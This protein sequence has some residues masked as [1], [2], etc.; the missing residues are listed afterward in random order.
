MMAAFRR[1]YF[2]LLADSAETGLFDCLAHHIENNLREK[3]EIQL[4]SS[5]EMLRSQ[6]RYVAVE[7]SGVREGARVLDVAGGTADLTSLFA[8]RVG[9]TG[10]VVLTDINGANNFAAASAIVHDAPGTPSITTA[11]SAAPRS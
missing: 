5:Q 1:T 11:N 9:A 6:E 3:G 4:T 7:T 8:Q 10:S 2:K